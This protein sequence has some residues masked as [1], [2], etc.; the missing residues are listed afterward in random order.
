MLNHHHHHHHLFLKRL[1][2]PRSARVRR[3][4]RYEV[5]SHIP[6]H[7]P[8]MVQTQLL[9]IILHT[10][11]PSLPAPTRTFHPCHHHISTGRHPII[12]ILTLH[13]PKPPQSTTPHHLSHTLNPQKTEQIHTALSILQRHPIHLSHYH[14][15]RPFQT[16]QICYFHRPGF[17]PIC[18]YTLDTS[19]VYLSLYA[20]WCTPSCSDRRKLLE[21]SP[22]TSYSGS[23]RLLHASSGTKRVTQ[24]AKLGNTFQLHIGLHHNLFQQNW[25]K[26]AILTLQTSPAMEIN[27]TLQISW[28]ATTSFVNPL[29]ALHT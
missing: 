11:S 2:L 9:H 16:L 21:L 12:S 20:V 22:S 18:Q 5:S 10:F 23:C 17:S 8:F 3:F 13:M 4:S 6:E 7:Y 19:F 26:K 15:F 1:F 29:K 28:N 14:P 25:Q 24:I 27:I